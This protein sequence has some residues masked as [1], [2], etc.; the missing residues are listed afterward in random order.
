MADSVFGIDYDE[1]EGGCDCPICQYL[2]TNPAPKN[3]MERRR[4]YKEMAKIVKNS[5]FLQI[6][7]GG[8]NREDVDLKEGSENEND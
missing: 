4:Q 2:R 1:N 8:I 7:F 5:H 6:E 3:R